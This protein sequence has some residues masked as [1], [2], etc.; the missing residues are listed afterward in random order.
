MSRTY[1]LTIQTPLPHRDAILKKLHKQNQTEQANLWKCTCWPSILKWNHQQAYLSGYWR[2]VCPKAGAHGTQIAK[3]RQ[4]LIAWRSRQHNHRA[5][6]S[7]RH[8]PKCQYSGFS[9]WPRCFCPTGIPLWKILFTVSNLHAIACTWALL[10]W[11]QSNLQ[12]T[13]YNSTRLVI[14]PCNFRVWY[15]G[16]NIRHW[17]NDRFEHC[18]KGIPSTSPWWPICRYFKGCWASNFLRG[19]LLWHYLMLIDDRV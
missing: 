5:S 9:R 10:Y 11:H 3:D 4:N 16:C 19:R 17:Q 12:E 8:W 15:S 1:R 13:Q 7:S 2:R 6:C 18:V 14:Y